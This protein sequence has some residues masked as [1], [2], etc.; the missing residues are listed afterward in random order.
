MLSFSTEF[1]VFKL[2]TKS[3]QT[4]IYIT[5]ILYEGEAWSVTLR[6]VNRLRVFENRVLYKEEL[7][8]LYSS[9]NT[10]GI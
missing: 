9:P 8:D 4:K 10:R 2:A 6:E 3:V 5:I 1:F 7:Y